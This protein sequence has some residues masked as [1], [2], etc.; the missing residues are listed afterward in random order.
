MLGAVVPVFGTKL[1]LIL[2][3]IDSRSSKGFTFILVRIGPLYIMHLA[4]SYTAHVGQI[5]AVL[6]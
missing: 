1:E 2:A 6:M 3:N 5:A 4:F